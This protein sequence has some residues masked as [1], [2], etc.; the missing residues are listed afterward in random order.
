M[1][2]NDLFATHPPLNDRIRILRA[3]S[4]ASFSDYEQSYEKI[5]SSKVM[6]AS[7]LA[8]KASVGVRSA[9]PQAQAGE[10]QD[11][12]SRT[13]ETSNL[14]WKMNNYK[15]L[16]CEIVQGNIICSY[17]DDVLVSGCD[18]FDNG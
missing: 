5:K 16:N 15:S 6:P 13:R 11:Q 12:I 18:I 3:M 7:A 4:G 1:S 14:L 17:S 10:I 9:S 8:D 2:V